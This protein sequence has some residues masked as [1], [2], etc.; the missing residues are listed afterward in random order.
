MRGKCRS[1]NAPIS[2]LYPFIELLTAMLLSLVVVYVPLHYFFSYFI[3]FSALIVTIRSDLE[4]ML[5]SRFVT[6]ALVPLGFIFS[7][8]GL[9][10]LTLN[11]SILGCFF[12][13][14]MLY[15]IAL[16]FFAFTKRRGIGQ[17][18]LEL[19]AL[20]GSFTGILGCWVSL[21]IGS[22][23]GSLVSFIYIA[24]N[25][26]QDIRT[27]KIPFGP[28][29]AFGAITFVLMQPTIVRIMLAG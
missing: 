24:I 20:I 15:S 1:C 17:G 16:I 29:L 25:P 2:V 8:F 12:G 18:D 4:T 23:M 11:E 7:A 3:F 27:L 9:L 10:P 22:I 28:F 26:Q 6:L 5:I 19:L 13:Y 21:L 14:G